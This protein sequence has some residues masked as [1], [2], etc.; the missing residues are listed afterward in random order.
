MKWILAM[1]LAFAV[2]AGCGDEAGTARL[3]AGSTAQPPVGKTGGAR[4]G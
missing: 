1:V 4:G 3:P 2:A